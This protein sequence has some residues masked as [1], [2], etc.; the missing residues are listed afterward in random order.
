MDVPAHDNTHNPDTAP[1]VHELPFKTFE[2]LTRVALQGTESYLA[3]GGHLVHA[4]KSLLKAHQLLVDN[5]GATWDG[6]SLNQRETI[7]AHYLLTNAKVLRAF[8]KP[9]RA[10]DALC[11]AQAILDYQGSNA[12]DQLRYQVAFE[13]LYALAQVPNSGNEQLRTYQRL[14]ELHEKYQQHQKHRGAGHGVYT[15]AQLCASDR[16]RAW[17]LAYI[18]RPALFFDTLFYKSRQLS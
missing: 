11:E 14:L 13:Y 10:A 9:Q 18:G 16:L 15:G 3:L 6:P 7:R 12:P 2:L 1:A 8:K 5:P 4:N 17:S